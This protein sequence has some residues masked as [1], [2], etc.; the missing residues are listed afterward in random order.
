MA[1]DGKQRLIKLIE[2]SDESVIVETLKTA[3]TIRL[4]ELEKQREDVEE[5]IAQT[6][7]QLQE[8]SGETD[9]SLIDP[10]LVR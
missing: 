9:R 5:Q 1:K 3:L 2:Q 10:E 4:D 7:S 6:R 8:I